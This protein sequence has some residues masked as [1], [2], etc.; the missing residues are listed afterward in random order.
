MPAKLLALGDSWFHYPN[1]LSRDGL[2]VDASAGVG[3]ILHHLIPMCP[4]SVNFQE[5]ETTEIFDSITGNIIPP[6]DDAFGR[7][8]EELML[9][10]YGYS[11]K[12]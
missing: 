6:N 12:D 8:G 5:K 9:M 11:R 7:C 1:A 3:N 4:A 2:P 10:V